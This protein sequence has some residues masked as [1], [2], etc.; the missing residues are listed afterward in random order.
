MDARVQLADSRMIAFEFE[1]CLAETNWDGRNRNEEC[2]Q[3]ATC[4]AYRLSLPGIPALIGTGLRGR[5][6]RV[7]LAGQ[8]DK[9]MEN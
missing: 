1:S 9:L 5:A 3:A 4:A 8:I 6:G 7:E 2:F